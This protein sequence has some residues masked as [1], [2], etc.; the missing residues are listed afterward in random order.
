[1]ATTGGQVVD[2]W[3][4]DLRSADA[5]LFALLDTHECDRLERMDREADRGRFAL[6]AALLRLAV[7]AATGSDPRSVTVERT[8]SDCGG[9]HGAPR[10]VGARV[11]VSHA[12]PL[13]LVATAGVAVGVDVESA[14]RGDDIEH[15]VG[16]EAR[17]KAGASPTLITTGMLRTPR[18]GYL[19]ALAVACESDPDVVTHGV[20]ESAAALEQLALGAGP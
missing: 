20:E 11:S 19:A 1:M 14:D 9:A 4:A 5:R 12:G 18:P 7:A 10:V 13:V 6:G 15:W 16:E 3:W 2:V 8:C 17:F